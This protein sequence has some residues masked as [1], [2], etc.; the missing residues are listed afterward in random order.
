MVDRYFFDTNII[1]YAFD[2]SNRAKWETCRSLV[3]GGF[4]SETDS[5]VSNQV[6]AELFVVLTMKV[7]R[8]ITSEKAGLIVRSFID[9]R[10]WKKVNY[11]HL[12]V[13]R[14]VAD[15]RSIGISFWDLLIAETMR[16]A[17]LKKIY[18]ENLRDFEKISW[19]EAVNP[20]R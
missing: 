7:K 8:P 5:F 14:A 18:T 9:S 12:T 20:L 1:A 3:R 11:D 19:V 2:R 15:A 13:G 17:G 10:A 16:D 4:Q 6:L